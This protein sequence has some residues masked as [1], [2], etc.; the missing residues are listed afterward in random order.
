MEISNMLGKSLM[1]KLYDEYRELDQEVDVR[2]SSEASEIK[3][4]VREKIFQLQNLKAA[5][6]AESRELFRKL[7]LDLRF[8]QRRWKRQVLN[9]VRFR[10]QQES[11]L[12]TIAA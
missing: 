7:K 10:K 11:Y 3:I 5:N 6:D 2:V 12:P 9:D 4:L 8:A 1:G